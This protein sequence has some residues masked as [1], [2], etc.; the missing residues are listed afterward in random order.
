MIERFLISLIAGL[1]IAGIGALLAYNGLCMIPS[2]FVLPAFL[3]W[4]LAS[5]LTL[6]E[7]V[8]GCVVIGGSV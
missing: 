8:F 7:L 2:M 4:T 1:F 6:V 3:N 5:G